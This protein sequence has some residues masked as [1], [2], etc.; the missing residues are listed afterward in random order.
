MNGKSQKV[1]ILVET[2]I[3]QYSV[4]YDVSDNSEVIANS[5]PE[6]RFS[7][8]LIVAVNASVLTA[9]GNERI[10]AITHNAEVPGEMTVSKAG[11]HRWYNA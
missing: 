6:R 7:N 4:S 1:A 11:T 3:H 9:V 10:K 5:S 8:L 2:L